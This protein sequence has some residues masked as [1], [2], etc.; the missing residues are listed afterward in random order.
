MTSK[1]GNSFSGLAGL[2]VCMLGGR[3]I[4]VSGNCTASAALT[5]ST[6]EVVGSSGAGGSSIGG[7]AAALE[8]TSLAQLDTAWLGVA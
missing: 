4:E 6:M 5:V 8:S 1:L 7:E 2:K 3:G